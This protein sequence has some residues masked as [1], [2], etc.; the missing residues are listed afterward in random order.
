MNLTYIK[1]P[2]PSSPQCYSPR[3]LSCSPPASF[4]SRESSMEPSSEDSSPKGR[5]RHQSDQLSSDPMT[6]TEDLHMDFQLYQ[7]KHHHWHPTEYSSRPKLKPRRKLAPKSDFFQDHHSGLYGKSSE[8]DS[9]QDHC[10]YKQ[11]WLLSRPSETYTVDK[12][13]N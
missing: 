4:P 13:S 10:V 6:L 12:T 1:H 7:W 5:K 9:F 2:Q 8:F 3:S 11:N